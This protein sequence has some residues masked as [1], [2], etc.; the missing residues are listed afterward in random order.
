MPEA[1]NNINEESELQQSENTY[2]F[3]ISLMPTKS[4][5]PVTI[6]IENSLLIQIMYSNCFK[7]TLF[8]GGGGG[9]ARSIIH[10][11]RR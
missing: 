7:K 9:G 8:G 3:N 10:F 5:V 2:V 6:P 1:G 4:Q 11:A